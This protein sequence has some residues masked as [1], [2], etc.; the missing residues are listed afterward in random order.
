MG[1]FRWKL[2]PSI[3]RKDAS[4]L[5]VVDPDGALLCRRW[6]K[7][8]GHD[9]NAVRVEQVTVGHGGGRRVVDVSNF[10]QSSDFW[11]GG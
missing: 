8:H 7:A 6:H 3:D 4:K 9:F 2:K 1:L 10:E 11:L 5:L